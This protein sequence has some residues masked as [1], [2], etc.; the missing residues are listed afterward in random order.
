MN[1]LIERTNTPISLVYVGGECLLVYPTNQQAWEHL[2]S[3]V[4]IGDGQDDWPREVY[5]VLA[6]CTSDSIVGIPQIGQVVLNKADQTLGCVPKYKELWGPDYDA[7]Q[8]KIKKDWPR[9]KESQDVSR[10]LHI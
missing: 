5:L 8:E 2:S 9:I 4:A 1:K 7:F 6:L 10:L 3:L